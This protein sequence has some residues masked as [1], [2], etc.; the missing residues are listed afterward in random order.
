M[1]YIRKLPLLMAL[2][3]SLIAG[4]TGYFN[5]VPDKENVFRMTV[6]MVLFYITGYMIRN[7]ISDI[8]KTKEKITE[9][10]REKEKESKNKSGNESGRKKQAE[11]EQQRKAAKSEKEPSEKSGRTVDITADDKLDFG[12]GE[13]DFEAFPVADFIKNGSDQLEKR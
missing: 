7:I 2:A 13:D 5:R 10:E 3:S 11:R 8:L 4:L 1:D 12:A 9:E 6:V